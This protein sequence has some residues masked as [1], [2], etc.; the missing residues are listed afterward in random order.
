MVVFIIV[1][2]DDFKDDASK[3]GKKDYCF[4]C[5]FKVNYDPMI[6]EKCRNPA[7]VIELSKKWKKILKMSHVWPSI[8]KFWLYR[9]KY[10]WKDW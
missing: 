6:V 8:D 7:E 10:S 1:H 5:Q 3:L 2:V 4:N 9:F